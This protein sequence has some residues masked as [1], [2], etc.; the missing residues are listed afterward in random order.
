MS[1]E[2]FGAFFKSLRYC[3]HE[4]MVL[5]CGSFFNMLDWFSKFQP[6]NVS[7]KNEIT[8]RGE[9]SELCFTVIWQAKLILAI[10]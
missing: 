7:C 1:L 4:N 2:S 10:V 9:G 8:E 5:N 6:K 3:R